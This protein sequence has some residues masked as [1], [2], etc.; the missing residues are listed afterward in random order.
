[1]DPDPAF[2]VIELQDANKKKFLFQLFFCFL[3][4]EGTFTKFSTKKIQ[5]ESQ[6]ISNQRF[7]S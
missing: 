7:S 4:F 2:F 3:L 1:M 6:N 5:K